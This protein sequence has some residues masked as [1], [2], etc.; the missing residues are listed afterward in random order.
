MSLI[1]GLAGIIFAI[2]YAFL[3]EGK[4]GFQGYF[5]MPAFVLLLVGP[6]S[7]MMLSHSLTDLLTGIRLLFTAQFNRQ[8]KLHE[9]VIEILTNA[10]KSARSDGLGVIIQ[11][12]DKAKY[13]L[14]RDGLA[15]IVNDFKPDEIR[16]NLMAR[17][18]LKQTR[19]QLASSLFD[20]MS[21]LCPG[22]GMIGTLMGLIGMLSHMGDPA[23]IGS[24]MALA[25]ITTLYGLG[26]GTIIYGPWAEKI[27]LEA[28]RSLEIDMLVVEGVM[29][30]KGKKSSMHLKDLVKS[31]GAKDKEKDK[32]GGSGAPDKRGA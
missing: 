11:Y 17:I 14:L 9:E 3:N 4:G 27:A 15:L 29:N 31:Y 24:N 13:D 19:M 26:L 6:P 21:R 8:T 7:I 28:E 18:N 10:A 5:S 32:G 16:N 12:R 2:G 25:M 22:V 30:I 1:I 23:K 20:N